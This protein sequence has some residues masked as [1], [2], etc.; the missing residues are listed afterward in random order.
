MLLPEL[1]LASRAGQVEHTSGLDSIK[2]CS[3][4]KHY[5]SYPYK[6]NYQFNSRGFRDREW[7]DDVKSAIWCVGD[8]FTVGLGSPL[9]HTWTQQV[10]S[11]CGQP[12][13]NVSMDGAS[14]DWIARQA[15]NIIQT[16]QP[17]IMIIMW[18]YL[19]RREDPDPTLS[20]EER[21][22]SS[23]RGATEFEDQTN[24]QNCIRSVGQSSTNILHF[25]IPY[26]YAAAHGVRPARDWLPDYIKEVPQLDHSR[27]GHHFD[28][29]TSQWVA[30]QAASEL[31]L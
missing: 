3:D 30:Q 21:R 26:A 6:V 24:F 9:D 2:E 17:R 12:T 28:I 23:I 22:I 13:V 18:S 7:P 1:F 11:T 4:K 14:N 29:L 5:R 19:H 27:D 10:E 8:S 31:I 25:I 15:C 20:D 16:V